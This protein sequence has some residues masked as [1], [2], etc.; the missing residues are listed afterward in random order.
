[1]F[2]LPVRA[3][4]LKVEVYFEIWGVLL[5]SNF[6]YLNRK[7]NIMAKKY[8]EI[9]KKLLQ[10]NESQAVYSIESKADD[11]WNSL[12]EKLKQLLEIGIKQCEKGETRPHEEVM[13]EMKLRFNLKR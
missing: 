3:I 8:N 5:F 11:E 4:K 2:F 6:V 7:S 12:P 1:L 9:E 13:A 10:V